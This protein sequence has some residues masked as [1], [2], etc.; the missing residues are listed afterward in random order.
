MPFI[1]KACSLALM[2]FP[3]LN[4]TYNVEAGTITY[5]ASH[6]IG[7]AMD[8]PMGLLVPNIKSVHVSTL[9]LEET[10]TRS[11]LANPSF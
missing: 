8:T 5:R 6:N 9:L 11:S 10:K 3:V 4:S 7:L 2:L 1:V